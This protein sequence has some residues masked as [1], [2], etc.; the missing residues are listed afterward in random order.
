MFKRIVR[1]DGSVVLLVP[2]KDTQ[3]ATFEVLYK[4]GSRQEPDSLSGVSH[5]IEH[6]MFKGTTKRPHTADIA[7]ELDSVGAEYNAFTGKE[8]TGYYVM[9]DQKHLP[10]AVDTLADMLHNS[11]LEAEEIDRER[12]VIVE[13]INM[14]EDNPLMYIDDVFENLL[15][16]G[17]LLGRSIAGTREIIKN[18]PR[19]SL[20]RYYQKYYYHGNA[21]LGVAGNFNQTKFL[22][23]LDKLF[24]I[25]KK[26]ARVTI[27][28][29][30]IAQQKQAALAIVKREV[31]QVQLMLGFRAMRAKDK[32]FLSLQVLA[33]ILGGTMSSRLFIQIRE[34]LGLC[35]FVRAEVNGYEDISSLA[36]HAGLNKA[37]IYEALEAIKVELNKIQQDGVT[38]A[39]LRQ[40]KDNMRG[41]LILRLE[42]SHNYL[43]F[44]SAQELWGQP[45]KDI[46]V[47]LRELEAISLSQINKL[48]KDII[49]WPQSNLA[50]I[51]PFA[52][53]NKF[54][55]ILK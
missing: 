43:N 8:H 38:M 50:I 51:G 33:N 7:K 53:N 2:K 13:E 49:A 44:L 30:K 31:E 36:I 26:Q 47:V 29:V 25:T 46:N 9:A 14:Y 4:V 17:S 16:Q 11:K 12:G 3:A 19:E 52:E 34:R 21:V 28:P 18:V 32:R 42:S 20:W 10:M 23:L 5:F 40:A 48:A 45:I 15:Y 39:E 1:Q 41:R 35:Y 55:K 24:P 37:K 22:R 27:K 54:L 6:L